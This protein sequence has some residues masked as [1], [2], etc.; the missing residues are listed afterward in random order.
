MWPPLSRTHF[1]PRSVE[2]PGGVFHLGEVFD[3]SGFENISRF[4]RI[5]GDDL[6]QR[7]EA[8][9]E[10][11]SRVGR[12][13]A[14]AAFGDHHRV[15][16]DASDR[17]CLELFGDDFDDVDRGE[18]ADF[19]ARYGQVR[20]HGVELRRDEVGRRAVHPLYAHG[21]L[22]RQ[23]GDDRGAVYAECAESL[24]VGLDPGAAARIRA[25][26]RQGDGGQVPGFRHVFLLS[27]RIIRRCDMKM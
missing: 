11:V 21:V 20:T 24:E 19:R 8:L 7:E 3:F 5:G 12:E 23:R 17:M 26:Y 4:F 9:D 14:V 6:G 15:E 16:H 18:H 2:G 13:Q 22:R 1:A 27:R 10:R 25:R